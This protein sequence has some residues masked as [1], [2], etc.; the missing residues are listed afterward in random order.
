MI[1]QRLISE[2]FASLR[3]C[4]DTLEQVVLLD[5]PVRY[6]PGGH[7]PGSTAYCYVCELP[8]KPIPPSNVVS[9]IDRYSVR[10]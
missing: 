3:E 7:F 4:I 1:D 9:M 2:A 8:T 5:A 6:C 10:A